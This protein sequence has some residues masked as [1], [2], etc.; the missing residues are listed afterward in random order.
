L[1]VESHMQ[2]T[3]WCEPWKATNCAQNLIFQVL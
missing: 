1:N 2:L 3:D